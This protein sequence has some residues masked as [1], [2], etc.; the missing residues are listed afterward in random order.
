VRAGTPR[1]RPP[2]L[3]RSGLRSAPRT[4]VRT[5]DSV[6][7]S[8]VRTDA[9]GRPPDDALRHPIDLKGIPTMFQPAAYHTDFARQVADDRRSALRIERRMRRSARGDE[10]LPRLG[11][12]LRRIRRVAPASVP[13]A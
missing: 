4:P 5:A 2:G 1:G 7:R 3:G 11:A 12:L 9:G 13:A 10:R 6:V 8:V